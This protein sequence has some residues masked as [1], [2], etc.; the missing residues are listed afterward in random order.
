MNLGYAT[1]ESNMSLRVD[2]LF[3]VGASMLTASHIPPT[4]KFRDW[5]GLITDTFVTSQIAREVHWL[6]IYIEMNY[7]YKYFYFVPRKYYS[8]VST[9]YWTI[10]SVS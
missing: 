5:H 3:T 6:A 8:S 2:I 9:S 4:E 10:I 7:G 1:G